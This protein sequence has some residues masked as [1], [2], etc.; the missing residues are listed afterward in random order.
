[1]SWLPTPRVFLLQFIQIN[2]NLMVFNLIPVAPLDGEKVFEFFVPKS[3]KNG[4]RHIQLYGRRILMLLFFLLPYAGY[5]FAGKAVYSVT[6]T[7]YSFLLGGI[8]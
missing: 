1:M 6:N 4:W 3:M 7:L 8:R 2:L 5:D